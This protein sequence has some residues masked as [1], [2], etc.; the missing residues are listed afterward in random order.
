MSEAIFGQSAELA[1]V[2]R[3]L[4]EVRVGPSALV[5]EG[6]IGT[7]KTT[8]WR[9][10]VSAARARGYR[11]LACHPGE[12]E[13]QL[14]FAALGDLLQGVLDEPHASLPGPQYRAL[15]VAVLMED[16]E[17]SPPDQRSVAVA[18]LGILRSISE[19]SPTLV[20]VDD[21]QWM[22][23]ASARVLEFAL[24]R[25][26]SERVGI[27]V[28]LRTGEPHLVPALVHRDFPPRDPHRLT[29]APLRQDAL[30]A[31]FRAR[32]GDSFAR[33]ILAQ[34]TAA[35]GGNPL[36]ALEI[37]RAMLGGEVR[38]QPGERL[39]VPGTLQQ[40]VRGRLADLPTDVRE[41]LSMA[42]AV[43]EPTIGLLEKAA[44]RPPGLLA[45]IEVAVRAGVVE[46]AGEQ[47]R[48]THPLFASTLYHAVAPG[49]RRAL[50]RT[51]ARFVRGPDERARHLALAA[52]GPDAAVA[53]ALDEAARGAAARGA[54]DAA[55]DLSEQ[56]YRLTTRGDRAAGYRRR[57]EAAEYH[58]AAGDT[59]TARHLLEELATTVEPGRR[60]ADVLRRLA[61][62]RYRSDSCSVAAELLTRALDEAGTDVSLRAGIERDLAWAVALCGDVPDAAEH[63]RSALGSSTDEPTRRCCPSFLPRPAWPTSCLAQA[64][65][66]R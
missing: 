10:A 14:A 44:S 6:E 25:L 49:R 64:C 48:F 9:A 35:S 55:A 41:L 7:G 45:T 50:H 18:T 26:E 17:D 28:A 32:L 62:V 39:S 8:L 1:S 15:K 46:V 16:P 11:V 59:G 58:F 24:R 12:S 31:L 23:R 34:V 21:P 5:V 65:T 19:Q 20:A 61:R 53:A 3:F 13:A 4:D 56:A 30:D 57:L 38:P 29:P 42:A 54:P 63:A 66:P 51:L 22:D 40:F 47:L 60:R 27:A 36:F 52:E 43:S 2:E 33:P 37:A